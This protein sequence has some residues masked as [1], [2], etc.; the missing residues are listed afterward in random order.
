M[1][2]MKKIRNIIEKADY[3]SLFAPKDFISFTSYDNAKVILNRLEKEGLIKRLIDGIFYKPR[4]SVEMNDYFAI[5]PYAFIDK[6]SSIYDWNIC[7]YGESALNYLSLSTQVPSQY[8]FISDGPYREYD[9]E[10]IKVKFKHT[11]MKFLTLSF[12]TKTA[13]ESIKFIGKDK[14]TIEDINQLK[15]ELNNKEKE[16][17]YGYKKYAPVWMHKVLERITIND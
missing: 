11:N 6:I 16:E 17:L 10:G 3:N 8:V 1:S 5:S 15:R 7:L 13:I 12:K 9:L 4:F 14:L 2:D